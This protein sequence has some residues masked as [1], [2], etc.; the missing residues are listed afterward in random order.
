[1]DYIFLIIIYFVLVIIIFLLLR[2][3]VKATIWSSVVGAFFYSLIIILL[4]Q[5]VVPCTFHDN[6][7]SIEGV[8]II[9]FI[10]LV[11]ITI[12]ITDRISRDIDPYALTVTDRH[13]IFY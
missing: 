8:I 12:Y 5:A 9:A 6:R 13:V 10:V 1:M 4:I 2:I 3:A 7:Y 11:L